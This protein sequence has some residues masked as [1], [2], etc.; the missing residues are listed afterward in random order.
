MLY[1]IEA[2]QRSKQH[3][4]RPRTTAGALEGRAEC[5]DAP[6]QASAARARDRQGAG[7]PRR[8][9]WRATAGLRRACAALAPRTLAK[10]QREAVTAW[11][12]LAL[13]GAGETVRQQIYR[14]RKF[15]Y[16]VHSP[17]MTVVGIHSAS[18]LLLLL[19]TSELR[20]WRERSSAILTTYGHNSMHYVTVA[21]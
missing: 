12:R 10:C 3:L 18:S 6:L 11:H 8:V 13:R 9:R 1:I 16:V 20:G 17:L 5:G 14:S 19:L 4:A 15:R 21:V 7:G 2:W